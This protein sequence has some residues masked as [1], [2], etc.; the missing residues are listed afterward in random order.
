METIETNPNPC[1]QPKILDWSQWWHMM[2]FRG[3]TVLH[4]Q[5]WVPQQS[6]GMLLSL[7][8]VLEK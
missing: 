7:F 4:S 6:Q 5:H 2:R 8:N 3:E 1:L